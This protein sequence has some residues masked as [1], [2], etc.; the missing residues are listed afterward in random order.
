[1]ER[2]ELP[3]PQGGASHGDSTTAR[4]DMSVVGF[5]DLPV[6]RWTQPALTTVRQP[7][8]DMA[9]MAATT[10]LRIIDGEQVDTL[11]LELPTRL[12]VRGSTAGPRTA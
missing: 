11:R 12:E 8:L 6:A 4:A 2:A 10:L 7:L 3:L 9:S 1:M 5:D